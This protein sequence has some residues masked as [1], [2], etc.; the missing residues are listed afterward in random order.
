MHFSYLYLLKWSLSACCWLLFKSHYSVIL[1]YSSVTHSQK[2]IG[3]VSSD[4]RKSKNSPLL[5]SPFWVV[6]NFIL[7]IQSSAES[8]SGYQMMVCLLIHFQER[9]NFCFPAIGDFLRCGWGLGN[10]IYLIPYLNARNTCTGMAHKT[11]PS[12]ALINKSK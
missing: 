9:I 12:V 6:L 1:V 7:F 10:S 3:A 8:Y 5:P 4:S 11:N 2:F